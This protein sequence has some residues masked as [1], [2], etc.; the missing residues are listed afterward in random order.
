MGDLNL[1]KV[2]VEYIC[3]HLGVEDVDVV[4]VG[5]S[6]FGVANVVVVNIGD[7]DVGDVDVDVLLGS[8]SRLDVSLSFL[9]T[10]PSVVTAFGPSQVL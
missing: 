3:R 2:A 9:I 8:V 6:D 10:Q 4:D 7:E 5:V 1:E